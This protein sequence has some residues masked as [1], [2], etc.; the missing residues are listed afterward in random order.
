MNVFT[1]DIDLLYF[2]VST[3]PITCMMILLFLNEQVGGADVILV[4]L[5][6][7]EYGYIN[8][9]TII[10]IAVFLLLVL[11]TI[12]LILNKIQRSTC[13]PFVPFITAGTI[14]VELMS[15]L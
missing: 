5:L 13:M 3:I 2:G 14:M 10:S 15:C 7:A 9:V 8:L 6:G 4:A 11:T 1:V 12:L